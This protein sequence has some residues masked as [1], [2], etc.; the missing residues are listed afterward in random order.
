[1][2][3]FLIIYF[4][5]RSTCF[6]RFLRPS[7]G[8]HNCTY[9]FRYCQPILLLAAIVDEMELP[10]TKHKQSNAHGKHKKSFPNENYNRTFHNESIKSLNLTDNWTLQ[11]IIKMMTDPLI[12][13]GKP[14]YA[15]R[16]RVLRR[17]IVFLRVRCNVCVRC[18]I[19]I[20][21]KKLFVV[22][23]VFVVAFWFYW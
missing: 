21:L 2:Q 8:A 1:M 13:A 16:T 5:R 14:W 7:S 12:E 18:S 19:L 22:A 15:M 3:R 6:R 10:N 23:S 4:Y 11:T 9:S 17:P 20:L